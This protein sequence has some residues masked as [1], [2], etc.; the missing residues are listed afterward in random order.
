MAVYFWRHGLFWVLFVVCRGLS[1]RAVDI[2][3][4]GVLMLVGTIIVKVWFTLMMFSSV[5]S[6]AYERLELWIGVMSSSIQ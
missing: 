1:S 2:F 3:Y 6:K 5:V 4:T